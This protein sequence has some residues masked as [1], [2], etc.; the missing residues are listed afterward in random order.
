MK[1]EAG[2]IHRGI[3][4]VTAGHRDILWPDGES[5]TEAFIEIEP[6]CWRPSN[7]I[8]YKTAIYFIIIPRQRIWWNLLTANDCVICSCISVSLLL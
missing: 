3:P 8:T 5:I 4:D 2:L 1:S 6:T 7:I